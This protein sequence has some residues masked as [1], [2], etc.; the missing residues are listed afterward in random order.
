MPYIGMYFIVFKKLLFV[1][2]KYVPNFKIYHKII[3]IQQ[4][5]FRLHIDF[6]TTEFPST[7]KIAISIL[8]FDFKKYANYFNRH[9]RIPYQIMSH[10]HNHVRIS[11]HF[12]F[13]FLWHSSNQPLNQSTQ[14]NL[15]SPIKRLFPL[16]T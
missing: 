5:I 10:H 9:C 2:S 12:A 7:S 6:A 1:P 3:Y 11:V 15:N 13:F 14:R 16:S 8:S 4:K